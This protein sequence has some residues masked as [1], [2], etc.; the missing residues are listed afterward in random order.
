MASS[1]SRHAVTSPTPTAAITTRSSPCDRMHLVTVVANPLAHVIDLLLGGMKPHGYDHGLSLLANKKAHSL[2]VGWHLKLGF[3]GRP[4]PLYR[5]SGKAPVRVGKAKRIGNIADHQLD[6]TLNTHASQA[7]PGASGREKFLAYSLPDR[8][9]LTTCES[10]ASTASRIF[11]PFSAEAWVGSP[12]PPWR[13]ISLK[14][15]TTV[16]L[17]P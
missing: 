11:S 5:I 13:V 12:K 1:D 2:G 9:S 6:Y 8:I 15:C 14:V 3:P 4:T 7:K 16:T 17:P 10:F